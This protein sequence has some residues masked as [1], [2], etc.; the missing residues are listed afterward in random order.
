[1]AARIEEPRSL[2]D[3]FDTATFDNVWY[4]V[5]TI[6]AW[7]AASHW[8]LGVPYDLIQQADQKGGPAATHAEAVARAGIA[9]TTTILRSAGVILAGA[10]GFVAA[11]LVTAGF[12]SGIEMAKGMALLAIPLMLVAG[13]NA[14]LAF[15]LEASGTSGAALRRALGRRRFWNQLIGLGAV[16]M[17][18]AMAVV[19]IVAREVAESR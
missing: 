14:R 16:G 17:A 4:W 13:L 15:R 6:I 9:R 7:S 19:H 3:L 12:W 10:G 5:I 8:T 18:A 11:G 1:M 2:I